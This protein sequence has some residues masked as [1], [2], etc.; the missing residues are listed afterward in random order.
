M[1]VQKRKVIIAGAGAAA[2]GAALGLVRRGIKPCIIDVGFKKE[3]HV[4]LEGNFYEH[5]RTNDI[6][7]VAIGEDLRGLAN[8]FKGAAPIPVKLASPR[9]EFITRKPAA[10]PDIEEKL[11]GTIRSF[12]AGGL[13]NAWGAGLYRFTKDDFKGFPISGD[14][15]EPYYDMLTQ[16][17]GISGEKDDLAPFF[18]STENLLPPLKL[19]RNAGKLYSGYKKHRAASNAQGIYLGRPRLGVLSEEYGGRKNCD[20]SNLE[21]WQPELPH[22]YTPKYTLE[23]LICDGSVEYIPGRLVKSWENSDSGV[24]VHV[25]D[26]AGANPEFFEC[27]NFIIAAGV[28]NTAKIVLESRRDYTTSLTLLDNPAVQVPLV[29]PTQLGAKLETDAFGLTQLNLIWRQQ[30]LIQASILEITAP[31]RSEFFKSLPFSASANLSLMRYLLPAMSV[32]QVFYPAFKG[33]ESKISLKSNGSLSIQGAN[34]SIELTT[35][36]PLVKILRRFGAFTHPALMVKVPL[37]HSIHYAGTLPMSQAPSDYQ[38]DVS[39]K[40]SGENHVYIADAS[41]FPQLPAKNH[42][43][44]IMANAMRIGEGI[45]LKSERS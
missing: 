44:T 13:A 5:R 8:I 35:L 36:K 41:T 24:I 6:F 37:G 32:M 34:L 42:G 14:D 3:E 39:G 19:S 7:D 21:F 27:E 1:A 33:T 25:T 28:S 16:E 11:F 17:I 30:F 4:P 15:L 45:A 26:T 29:F 10:E 40:L 23:R 12:A 9:M 38:C 22:I 2:V 31:L 43:L 18:G 20:Y